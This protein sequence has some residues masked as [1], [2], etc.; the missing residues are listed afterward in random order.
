MSRSVSPKAGRSRPE[1]R[2][3]TACRSVT[4]GSRAG[5]LRANGDCGSIWSSRAARSSRSRSISARISRLRS[6]SDVSIPIACS[7]VTWRAGLVF[8]V[9]SKPVAMTVILTSSPHSL[10]DHGAEDDVGLRVGGLLDHLGRLVDLEQAQVAAAGDVEQ[11]AAR[12][13]DVDLQQRATSA[14]LAAS[15]ARFSPVP[16]PDAHQRRAGVAA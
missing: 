2:T 4:R 13:L 15:T 8:L 5:S 11:D 12:A 1:G 9:P 3:G 7:A 6:S 14:A 10:V 16:R